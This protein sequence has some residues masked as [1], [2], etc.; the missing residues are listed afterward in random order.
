MKW[1]NLATW[2]DSAERDAYALWREYVARNMN[3]A[4]VAEG[5]R[6]ARAWTRRP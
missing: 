2:Q 6:L 5:E 1:L 4:D 3:R